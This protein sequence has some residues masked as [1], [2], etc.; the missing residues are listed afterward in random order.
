M[1]T[2]NRREKATYT[3]Q[4]QDGASS[5]LEVG[6]DGVTAELIDFLKQSDHEFAL[7]KRYQ[8]DNESYAYQNA[9]S[10]YFSPSCNFSDHPM[11]WFTDP[12][13]TIEQILFSEEEVSPFEDMLEKL[14][15][16]MEMLTDGQRDLIR[17]LYG[18]LKTDVEIAAEQNV[19]FQA[20]QNRRKK[21]LKR[22]EKLMNA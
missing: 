1:A 21:M 6:K 20:I 13:A 4:F 16:V 7:Q 3:Y 22:I 10:K 15:S 14:D 18:L 19:T 8:D 17:D 5:S 11:H 9:V 2:I 12:K